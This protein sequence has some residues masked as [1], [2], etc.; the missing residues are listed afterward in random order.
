M[1]RIVKKKR[2][3]FDEQ[4]DAKPTPPEQV[5]LTQEDDHGSSQGQRDH[6]SGGWSQW[7]EDAE[8][9]WNQWDW[10]PQGWRPQ[11][12]HAA[13]YDVNNPF[14]H[15]RY[16]DW[17]WDSKSNDCVSGSNGQEQSPPSTPSTGH[18]LTSP[19]SQ[20]TLL[21]SESRD[22]LDYTFERMN[23]GDMMS[24]DAKFQEAAQEAETGNDTKDLG[25]NDRNQEPK[26]LTPNKPNENDPKTEEQ[27]EVK[28]E[29]KESEDAKNE[30]PKEDNGKEPKNEG[31]PA[32]QQPPP[33]EVAIPEESQQAQAELEA[34]R[35]EREEMKKKAHARY[36]KYYR[37]VRS[38]TPSFLQ[39]NNLLW[40]HFFIKISDTTVYILL[41][42]G[43]AN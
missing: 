4:P 41:R 24:L 5:D 40:A 28:K 18:R 37:A 7:R 13:Y 42:S 17:D 43:N 26:D 32:Q 31:K 34:K 1:K 8:D 11:K 15:Y 35:R 12:W 36:M 20:S 33:P 23:T 27:A 19:D 38:G 29:A 10:P 6:Y 25:G 30:K 21:E 16:F 3:K 2:A 22:T 14:H 9:K 39:E